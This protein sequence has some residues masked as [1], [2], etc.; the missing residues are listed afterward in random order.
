MVL[1][2][3][4]PFVGDYITRRVSDVTEAMHVIAMVSRLAGDF[5]FHA[6]CREVVFRP[7]YMA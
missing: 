3:G 4:L 1:R 7:E 2:L 6:R 5:L